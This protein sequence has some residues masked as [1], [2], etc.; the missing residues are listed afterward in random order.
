MDLA[1]YNTGKST[2]CYST[3]ARHNVI[4]T[5]INAIPI[6][7]KSKKKKRER[8]NKPP[9]HPRQDLTTHHPPKLLISTPQPSP[10]PTS[11]FSP[12]SN[13]TSSAAPYTPSQ[14]PPHPCR[15][16]L[17]PPKT[18]PP[19]PRPPSRRPPPRSR[20]GCTAR[21]TRKVAATGTFPSLARATRA[22]S[23]ARRAA[24]ARR[25]RARYAA[26]VRVPIG[27]RRG[28]RCGGGRR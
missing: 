4:R 11:P 17:L 2:A 13:D 7:K 22:P 28:R 25:R 5:A 20:G 9:K 3:R 16:R 15:R 18:T 12:S 24:R 26:A 10:R 21:A 27:A 23:C 19:S 6:H 14:T 8:R 1:G